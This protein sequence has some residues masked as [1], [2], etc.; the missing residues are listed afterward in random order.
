MAGENVGLDL[1]SQTGQ[2]DIVDA[3]DR[4]AAAIGN[5]S[6]PVA[7]IVAGTYQLVIDSN[8]NANWVLVS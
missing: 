3:I 4:L 2:E 8:G 7:P 6:L 5:A 1:A